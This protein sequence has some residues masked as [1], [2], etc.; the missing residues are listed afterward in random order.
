MPY[1]GLMCSHASRYRNRPMP[2]CPTRGQEA[3]TWGYL[4]R[5]CGDGYAVSVEEA[6]SDEEW[7]DRPCTPKSDDDD[8]IEV[9]V[10]PSIPLPPLSTF[11]LF[12][13]ILF[14]FFTFFNW[15]KS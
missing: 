15:R 13:V 14:A 7:G 11:P 3:S 4:I 2:S 1:S 10:P 12:L 5:V 6:D 8:L 9:F